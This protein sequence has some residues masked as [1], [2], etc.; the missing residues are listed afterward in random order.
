MLPSEQFSLADKLK[1]S[2][3]GAEIAVQLRIGHGSPKYTRPIQFGDL[4]GDPLELG[5]IDRRTVAEIDVT[6]GI[7]GQRDDMMRR[8]G[9][10]DRARRDRQRPID[11]I[12]AER[13]SAVV[14]VDGIGPV[15]AGTAGYGIVAV[16]HVINE[17]VGT[18]AATKRVI[19]QAAGD[20]VVVAVTGE[21][22][23][24]SRPRDVLDS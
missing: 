4:P 3:N 8:V 24:V 1:F 9:R 10:D 13:R 14:E 22:V 20:D 2:V 6:A 21:R 12:G 17:S 15:R 19:A 16:T 7:L 5:K 11:A 23:V 18:T